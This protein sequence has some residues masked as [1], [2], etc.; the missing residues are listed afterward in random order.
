[1]QCTLK[2]CKNGKHVAILRW[3]ITYQILTSINTTH[4]PLVASVSIDKSVA[5]AQKL[6]CA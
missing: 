1:M 2:V 6:I 5:S 4:I 3:N